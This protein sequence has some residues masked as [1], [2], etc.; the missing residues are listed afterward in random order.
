[1]VVCANITCL[2]LHKVVWFDQLLAPA[3][4]SNIYFRSAHVLYDKTVILFL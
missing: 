2:M 4:Y 3:K 1:M